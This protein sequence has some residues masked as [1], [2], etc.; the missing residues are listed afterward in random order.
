[1]PECN[2]LSKQVNTYSPGIGSGFITTYQEATIPEFS[3]QKG[4]LC[5]AGDKKKGRDFAGRAVLGPFKI[6]F[7]N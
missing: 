2:Y 6:C 5:Q 7:S 3:A 4:Y 1:M